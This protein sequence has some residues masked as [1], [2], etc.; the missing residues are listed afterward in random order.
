MTLDNGDDKKKPLRQVL[1][2]EG[3]SGSGLNL[4]LDGDNLIAGVWKQ[5]DASWLRAGS[6]TPDARHHVA[7]VLHQTQATLYLDG[8]KIADGKAP[9]LGAHTGDINLGRS[10]NTRFHDR[11]DDNP[12]Y[13]FAGRFDDFRIANRA[14][15][16]AEV[17]GLAK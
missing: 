9:L 13:Y 6:L 11:T 8:A 2:E 16:D 10:G 5:P 4:Y 7:F 15:S 3:G 12:G 1:Y 14:F 17:R